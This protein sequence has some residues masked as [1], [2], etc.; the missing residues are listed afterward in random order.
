MCKYFL[1][2]SVK[3][4]RFNDTSVAMSISGTRILI[5]KYYSS[6]K[7]TE[8]LGEMVDSETRVEK[9]TR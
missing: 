5:S 4:P 1:A 9:N 6:L 8:L 2:Q 7:G 3:G